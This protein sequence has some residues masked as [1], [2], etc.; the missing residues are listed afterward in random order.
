LNY[1][2][3]ALTGRGQSSNLATVRREKMRTRYFWYSSYYS[4]DIII[5]GYSKSSVAFFLSATE[6][7]VSLFRFLPRTI[8]LPGLHVEILHKRFGEN[9]TKHHG[10]NGNRPPVPVPGRVWVQYGEN[11]TKEK[12]NVNRPTVEFS[13]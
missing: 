2:S 5:S 6:T 3:W 12:K 7:S 1:G 11:R 13:R 8:P 4:S 9:H 10:E